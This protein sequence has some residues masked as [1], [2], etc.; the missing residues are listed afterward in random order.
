MRYHTAFYVNGHL[1][2]VNCVGREQWQGLIEGEIIKEGHNP[3]HLAKTLHQDAKYRVSIEPNKDEVQDVIFEYLDGI[4]GWVLGKA[5][6]EAI[7]PGDITGSYPY[8]LRLQSNGRITNE[9]IYTGLNHD[10]MW[11]SLGNNDN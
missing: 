10:N 11:R 9:K 5:V 8:L 2:E 6:D 7:F 3:P 4:D 1:C